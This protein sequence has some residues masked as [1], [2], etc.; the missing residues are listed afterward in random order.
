[1]R[2]RK[3]SQPC[4]ARDLYDDS[5]LWRGRRAYAERSGAPWCI[6]SA[7]YGLLAPEVR[8]NPYDLALKHIKRGERRQRNRC[9]ERRS[10][11]SAD[12]TPRRSDRRS[13]HPGG[14]RVTL[15]RRSKS[16]GAGCLARARPTVCHGGAPAG[17]V[18]CPMC[19][20]A[21][22]WAQ[23][24]GVWLFFV[25]GPISLS[26]GGEAGGNW[27]GRRRHL[28]RRGRRQLGGALRRTPRRQRRR[29]PGAASTGLSRPAQG[30]PFHLQPLGLPRRRRAALHHRG[31]RPLRQHRAAAARLCAEQVRRR[32]PGAPGAGART[33][34]VDTSPG[35][36][37]GRLGHRRLEARRPRVL[38]LQGMHRDGNRARSRLA[39]RRGARRS[40]G[41]GHRPS[42]GNR[43]RR[44]Q[45][46]PRERAAGAAL[47]GV[48]PLDEPL[49]LSGCSRAARP[50]A[51]AACAGGNIGRPRPAPAA[52]LLSA[53][54]D[55]WCDRPGAVPG[56]PRQRAAE[57][58][59]AGARLGSGSR[60]SATRRGPPGALL[61]RVHGGRLS[62]ASATRPLVGA[63]RCRGG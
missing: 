44:D 26:G 35:T 28:P 48:R 59:H 29:H 10:A 43:P 62:S 13:D 5:S 23:Q 34:H 32:G 8:I 3:R 9:R 25:G 54:P 61:Q 46:L 19:T 41:T 52:R 60:L 56:G 7:K 58:A 18:R 45:R 37:H 40:G 36:A 39:H 22:V 17:D 1:M 16:A 47:A 27:I 55:G 6:L 20:R 12:P 21:T 4:P 42:L 11:S 14:R 49:R 53:A 2:W 63:R 15:R 31:R 57:P 24:H 33:A 50:L 30:V 38:A 51:P